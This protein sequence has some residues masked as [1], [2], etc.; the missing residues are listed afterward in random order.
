[1]KNTSSHVANGPRKFLC[2][3][4]EYSEKEKKKKKER[5]K[6]KKEKREW[7]MEWEKR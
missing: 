1:M 3:H 5:K 7:K 4:K 2:L 6:E